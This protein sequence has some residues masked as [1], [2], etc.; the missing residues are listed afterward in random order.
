MVHLS[1]EIEVEACPTACVGR[2]SNPDR[3]YH[4][5]PLSLVEHKSVV[6]RPDTDHVC[7][8]KYGFET[9][10]KPQSAQSRVAKSV[11]S[12]PMPFSPVFKGRCVSFA[13]YDRSK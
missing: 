6:A 9:W 12:S 2:A 1:G 7:H 10:V 5:E 11:R 3:S 4:A 13:S 8:R